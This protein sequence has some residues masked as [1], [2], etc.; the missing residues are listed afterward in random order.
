M[1]APKTTGLTR[2]G[3]LTAAAA[4]IAAAKPEVPW[5]TGP[6]GATAAPEPD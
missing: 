2:R 1:T 3:A 6:D 5:P 4:T